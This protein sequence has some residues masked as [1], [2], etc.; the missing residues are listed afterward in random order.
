MGKSSTGEFLVGLQ[1]D[2]LGGGGDFV[3]SSHG[4]ID[5]ETGAS[6]CLLFTPP[7]V[8]VAAGAAP[9]TVGGDIVS[10]GQT[11]QL[12]LV[13]ECASNVSASAFTDSLDEGTGRGPRV[14]VEWRD[15]QCEEQSIRTRD[16]CVRGS[17][18]WPHKPTNGPRVKIKGKHN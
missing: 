16:T 17:G 13:S 10:H 4:Q 5:T 9:A 11:E 8:A 6:T 3:S 7:D 12:A 14:C 15:G 2:Y 18:T 1:F